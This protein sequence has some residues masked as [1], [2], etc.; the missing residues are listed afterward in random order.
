[1]RL[2]VSS[3]CKS[4]FS[5]FVKIKKKIKT[6]DALGLITVCFRHMHYELSQS[7]LLLNVLF[8]S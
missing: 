7:I 6:G 5:L 2:A 3:L 8:L 1:M 4:L